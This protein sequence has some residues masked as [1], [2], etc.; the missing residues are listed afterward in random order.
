MAEEIIIICRKRKPTD[1]D[2]CGLNQEHEIPLYTEAYFY[3]ENIICGECVTALCKAMNNGNQGKITALSEREIEVVQLL[4]QGKT[5]KEIA[6]EL[7]ISEQTVKTHIA[8]IYEKL[9]VSNR[10]EA[11]VKAFRE[12]IVS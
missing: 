12:G 5:N 3:Q 10:T 2:R 6:R 1:P 9:S 8:R 11:V 4:V 7:F